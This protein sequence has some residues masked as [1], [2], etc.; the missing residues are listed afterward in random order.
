MLICHQLLVKVSAD[1]ASRPDA[2]IRSGRQSAATAVTVTRRVA[3][4]GSSRRA[5]RIQNP[6]GHPPRSCA[7]THGFA[8]NF[9]GAHGTLRVLTAG[10]R[11]GFP[12]R[13]AYHGT[14]Y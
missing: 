14:V 1:S 9:G 12:R 2:S 7:R 3:R 11:S 10:R 4:A 6:S 13:V 8:E 5:R